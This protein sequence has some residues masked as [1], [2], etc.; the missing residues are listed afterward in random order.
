MAIVQQEH[1]RFFGRL[2][3]GYSQLNITLQVPTD[4][5]FLQIELPPGERLYMLG[6]NGTGKSGLVHHFFTQH[7][8]NARRISAHRQT[9]F[10]SDSMDMTAQTRRRSE[11]RIQVDDAQPYSRWKDDLASARPNIAVYD[12]IDAENIRAREITALVERGDTGK[13]VAKA[14][15]PAPVSS[16]NELM[17][18]SGIPIELAVEEN[19]RVVAS[20]SGS[21]PYSI[22]EL[23]DG[24]RNALLMAASVLTAPQGTLILVDEPERHLHRSIVTPLLHNLFERRPDCY[25]VIST[26]EVLLAADDPSAQVLL[27]RDCAYANR[28]ATS[29][30]ADLLEPE[31]DIPE[32]V[33]RDILGARRK[34]LF[35]EGTTES[36]DKP[37][38]AL[39]FP[40][41]TV[42]PKGSCGEVI[43]CVE[44]IRET[45]STHWAVPFGIVDGDG[46]DRAEIDSLHNTGI[47]ATE[48]YSV[49]SIY[50]HPKVLAAIAQRVSKLDGSDSD[51]RFET[52]KTAALQ[53]A[54]QSRDHLCKQIVKQR[55]RGEIF[56]NLPGKELPEE[57]EITVP[58]SA[59]LEDEHKKF[60]QAAD[61]ND[62]EALIKRYPLR[63]SSG[64]YR[65]GH[66]S[67]LSILCFLRSRCREGRVGRIGG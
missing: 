61:A 26:H 9:W 14:K 55:V 42:V 28:Q 29:W 67:G 36:L 54:A 65:S 6:Q 7:K 23:S 35:V 53:S 52:A 24:E 63:K 39:L 2:H 21:A 18:L 57:I 38:Y 47:V 33:R 43:R 51:A 58:V 13:A 40:D 22:A 4:K 17:Q 32:E 37:L 19:E 59:Y 30:S 25:F 60:D 66:G 5:V 31:S 15:S 11:D 64:S 50:Y 45:Q 34:L 20:R 48:W 3:S 44:A 12:L 27:L 10:T 41:S 1:H 46:R 16:I 56:D 8:K 49:E 62:Y